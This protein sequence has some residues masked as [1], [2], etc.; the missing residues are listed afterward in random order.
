MK[1]SET[2]SKFLNL[3]EMDETPAVGRKLRNMVRFD[4]KY[5]VAMKGSAAL[6]D[7][8]EEASKQEGEDPVEKHVQALEGFNIHTFNEIASEVEGGTSVEDAAANWGED[9][10]PEQVEAIKWA[11]KN[12]V[13]KMKEG[14]QGT[15]HDVRDVMNSGNKKYPHMI[16]AQIDHAPYQIHMKHPIEFDT[17]Y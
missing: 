11:V 17:S 15:E 4:N 12:K 8:S 7:L 6:K 9:V 13:V 16:E 14:G 5:K 2:A 3:F 1:L 10:T